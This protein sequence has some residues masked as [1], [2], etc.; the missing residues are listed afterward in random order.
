MEEARVEKC[1]SGSF[2]VERLNL[3][4]NGTELCTATQS[5]PTSVS[6]HALRVSYIVI[7]SELEKC[8]EEYN[9]YT[10]TTSTLHP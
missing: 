7:G 4:W 3:L 8:S 2:L 9:T 6:W 1:S 10:L 5:L